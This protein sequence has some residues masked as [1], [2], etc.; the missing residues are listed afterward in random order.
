[1]DNTKLISIYVKI[2]GIVESDEEELR[3]LYRKKKKSIWN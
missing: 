2:C 1:M 3:Q